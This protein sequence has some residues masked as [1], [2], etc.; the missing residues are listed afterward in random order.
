MRFEKKKALAL[1]KI[2]NQPCQMWFFKNENKIQT[3]LNWPDF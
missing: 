1:Q 2:S 3:S